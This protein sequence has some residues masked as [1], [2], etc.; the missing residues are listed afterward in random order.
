MRRPT[1]A[2]ACFALLT[3]AGCG[4][5]RIEPPDPTR[6]AAPEGVAP[7]AYPTAGLFLE[8]PGNWPFQAG[9][10]PLVASASSGTATVALWRYVR[11]EPLPRADEELASAQD[12]LEQAVRARDPSF[13]LSRGR[14]VE[15]DGAPGLQLVGTE[16]VAGKK[17]RVRS[18]H[19]YAKGAEVVLDAYAPADEFERVDRTVFAPILESLKI[20]PPR[21]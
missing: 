8:R 19:V 6:P 18:T 3:T 7:E 9:R 2:A 10:P 13:E 1:A 11:S 12:L 14:R 4:R 17:R 5:E 15:V 16:T 20:D 21:G